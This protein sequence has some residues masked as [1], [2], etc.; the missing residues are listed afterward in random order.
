[1]KKII[2]LAVLGVYLLCGLSVSADEIAEEVSE[3][4]TG[5]IE[6]TDE[7]WDRFNATLPMIVNVLPNEIALNRLTNSESYDIMTL[8][9]ET[10][11]NI[12]TAALGEEL[13][14]S[15][16]GQNSAGATGTAEFPLSD[17]VDVS[18]S[19]T[20][21]PIGNQDTI[22]S[23][24]AWSLGY[25]QLTNNNCVVRGLSAKDS[26]GNAIKENI[27]SPAFIYE[28]VNGGIDNG[29]FY[30]EACAA[31]LN[32]GCPDKESYSK[33]LTSSNLKKWC[34]DNE[35]WNLALY[36]KPQ[37]ITYGEIEVHEPVTAETEGVVN[38]KKILS[39]GYVVTV[40]TFVNSFVITKK[41]SSGES[42]CRYMR[43]TYRGSHAMTVV[44]YD[45]SFWVD[46]NN[47][48]SEDTGEIGAF[49]VANS[50]G[51]NDSDF[52]NGY[53]WIP[54][55][56]LGIESGVS[57][58]STS[59][60]SLFKNY[61]FI[62]P[63]KEYTPLLVANVE[64][65]T[66]KRNQIAVRVGVSDTNNTEPTEI[67]GVSGEHKIAFNSAAESLLH[68]QEGYTLLDKSFK[69][70][71]EEETIVVP[72]DLTPVITKAYGNVGRT[73]NSD[74]RIYI[75]VTDT[76]N[77]NS[78]ITLGDVTI[79]EPITGKSTVCTDVADKITNNNSVIK[80]VDL[81]ITPFLVHSEEQDIELTFNNNIF[82]GSTGNNIYWLKNNN[83]SYPI[84]NESMFVS[85]NTITLTP[86][87]NKY[88]YETKY[89]L[90]IS[91]NLK[92][93]GG[94][95]MQNEKIVL[96]YALGEFYQY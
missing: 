44:G 95:L 12:E 79:T 29:A 14:Y 50:W 42:G 4:A 65:T 9:E 87:N 74:I 41:T 1:M 23:C 84:I 67:I 35:I 30:D 96:I 71:S 47:N 77:D 38:I 18:E 13:I 3:N 40:P 11:I 89:E 32:Y 60:E 34:T 33:T 58:V 82:A 57:G 53:I 27:M 31:I 28:L 54:Y 10:D 17:E 73:E 93:M 66:Q 85:N 90:H 2:T 51:K 6:M 86:P 36:N 24:V 62:E 25:Y 94:N 21:P 70:T 80:T 52:T 61:Y 75:E 39:N 55:D 81:K 78:N 64:L 15:Y 72:F 56:A 46:V 16:P 5:L 68:T 48:G 76:V 20:F 19:L 26:S 91:G 49:K 43:D 83:I 7:Q 37:K 45:D 8:S 59:R 88:T 69:N 22:N 92:T 63:K